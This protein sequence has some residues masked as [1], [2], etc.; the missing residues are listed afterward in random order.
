MPVE[1]HRPDDSKK[2][3]EGEVQDASPLNEGAGE[4]KEVVSVNLIQPLSAP[5]VS[6]RIGDYLMPL[7]IDTGA[8]VSII[9][10]DVIDRIA[11]RMDMTS[12][13]LNSA[14][15]HNITAVGETELE[16]IIGDQRFLH[17]FVVVLQ[18]RPACLGLLG[19]DFLRKM[20][21]N[22][23]VGRG[24][25]ILN[26]VSVK[27]FGRNQMDGMVYVGNEPVPKEP[28]IEAQYLLGENKT[29]T[30]LRQK[31]DER[32]DDVPETVINQ[33][34]ARGPH[35]KNVA[36]E[37]TMV[38]NLTETLIAE[39][40]LRSKKPSEE[41]DTPGKWKGKAIGPTY[42]DFVQCSFKEQQNL[43]DYERITP[44]MATSSA[45]KPSESVAQVATSAEE[46]DVERKPV[47]LDMSLNLGALEHTFYM[48]KTD[49]PPG[50]TVSIVNHRENASYGVCN[51]TAVVNEDGRVPALFTN[52]C[53]RNI[54]LKQGE[55]K[56]VTAEICTVESEWFKDLREQ[57]GFEYC[58]NCGEQGQI[59]K[60]E[61]D[62]VTCESCV[63]AQKGE[64]KEPPLWPPE[65][66]PAVSDEEFLALFDLGPDTF[67]V[68][69]KLKE[70]L[71]KHKEAF[72][73]GEFDLGHTK[74]VECEIDTGDHPP[75]SCP[76]YNVPFAQRPALEAAL[77]DMLV[78]KVIEPTDSPWAFPLVVVP[79]KGPG[80]EF[81][82]IRVCA[83][84]RKLNAI[85]KKKSYHF[86]TL[87]EIFEALGAFHEGAISGEIYMHL[88]DFQTGFWQ[89]GLSPDAAR[90]CSI[91]TP[92]GHFSFTRMP[93][94]Y[95][96]APL[97]FCKLMAE[98]LKE[99]LGKYVQIFVDDCLIWHFTPHGSI[100]I[101]DQ[102]LT[103]VREAGLRL[104][105]AK[106]RFLK[107]EVNFL[108]H[109]ISKEGLKPN[110]EKVEA[111]KALKPMNT[112][113]GVR[114]ISGAFNFYRK[115]I[116]DYTKIMTPIH[117]LMKGGGSSNS[118][119]VWTEEALKA[120]EEIKEAMTTAPVLKFP[121]RGRRFH[122]K[123][124][125][126]A[127]GIGA[128][129]EQCWPEG[130]HPVA[131]FSMPLRGARQKYASY[132][133]ECVGIVE[134]LRHFHNYLFGEEFTLETDCLPLIWL[135]K[136]K[137]P[138]SLCAR[139]IIE[140]CQYNFK[141]VHTN[142]SAIG[143]ADLLSRQEPEEPEVNTIVCSI[144][145]S[146]GTEHRDISLDRL[147]RAQRADPE[148]QLIH[149]LLEEADGEDVSGYTYD[150]Q[151]VLCKNTYKGVVIWMPEELVEDCLHNHHM[152]LT[153]GH[154]GTKKTIAALRRRFWWKG[155]GVDTANYIRQ[156]LACLKRKGRVDPKPEAQVTQPPPKVMQRWY[157]DLVGPLV[158]TPSGNRWV[159][160]FMEGVSRWME[161]APLSE[162]T[163]A[164]VAK[165][166]TEQ[167]ICRWGLFEELV[168]DNG[169]C[170][171]AELYKEVCKLLGVKQIFTSPYHPQGNNIEPAHKGMMD[172]VSLFLDGHESW[173]DVL[174]Y[175]M[176]SARANF[177]TSTQA[178]PS[179]IMTGR[180]MAL[181]GD[182]ILGPKLENDN[183]APT[184][185][186]HVSDLRKRLKN[187][188]AEARKNDC[189]V[190][191]KNVK[192]L[193]A[194]VQRE[195][196]IREGDTVYIKKMP[197]KGKMDDRLKGPFRVVKERSKVTFDLE[198]MSGPKRKF[199]WHRMH[200]KK[201]H[202]VRKKDIAGDSSKWLEDIIA[203]DNNECDELNRESADLG[204]GK[205]QGAGAESSDASSKDILPDNTER[206]CADAENNSVCRAEKAKS[207]QP[208]PVGIPP[209]PLRA[210][211]SAT[212]PAHTPR[213][214]G[215]PKKVA[216]KPLDGADEAKQASRTRPACEATE[217]GAAPTPQPELQA[218]CKNRDT[219]P[220]SG[221]ESAEGA[222]AQAHYNLR[223]RK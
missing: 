207:A 111:L 64:T 7:V 119:V 33:G 46:K 120:L 9:S 218:V 68:Q 97:Y 103:R 145:G 217:A 211:A 202:L 72:V 152:T 93:F 21:A 83:D 99:L 193:N 158:E 187:V 222:A 137:E 86:T 28:A 176:F 126:S 31:T 70:V 95:I 192:R 151:G 203:Q 89:I 61:G 114:S 65:P 4:G 175:A 94:G 212:G 40:K 48:L 172:F 113:K 15:G 195:R 32:S 136:Q 42:V 174:P 6:V 197:K 135:L 116:K 47:Y 34:N 13:V 213:K 115:F 173:E 30:V 169:R 45:K 29:I 129:L 102:V 190:R 141:V 150:T 128:V 38:Q 140:I 184:V 24:R 59:V 117:N 73:H 177:H 41:N 215:R 142:G 168:C 62:E 60:K 208:A 43:T 106:C 127:L 122:L 74:V 163:A 201:G 49:F 138:K 105:P 23:D 14:S 185:A 56:Q 162:A 87:E 54:M 98:V 96:H 88:L 36:E 52:C 84:L 186:Q 170:F 188:R 109:T 8:E 81:K 100:D 147:L 196:P 78:K 124:D 146:G 125:T 179:L 90:K 85:C 66:V 92:V 189:A 17:E 82:S 131:F 139:M 219:Q 178:T 209:T 20:G 130:K 75:I 58:T 216:P 223:T 55:L 10:R 210:K 165:A 161:A 221:S 156:C 200:M 107:T 44:K 63:A 26:G 214:R 104:N 35:L 132:Q 101:L 144:E 198:T 118:K 18:S 183:M 22:V 180:E 12:A 157:V 134:A 153:G 27:L 143:M 3:I 1:Q 112:L 2:L 121:Q 167:V 148:M 155:M 37:Q 205:V 206:K 50:S 77:R 19:T 133:L 181:P 79:K 5:V 220:C 182:I 164:A 11:C 25:M 110:S 80:G 123:V 159:V 154:L 149:E 166:L 69:T 191:A 199:Q 194:R 67:G 16:L 171:T 39:A 57:K 91:A 204:G 108:G 51:F 53:K 71:L 160:T 76:P